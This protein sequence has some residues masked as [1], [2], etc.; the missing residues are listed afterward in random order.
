MKTKDYQG[1]FV[2]LCHRSGNGGRY[3][4]EIYLRGRFYSC[5]SNNSPAWDRV[6]CD[7]Y[8]PARAV[9]GGYT[10]KGAFRAL[11]NECKRKNAIYPYNIV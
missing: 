7:D 6:H 3:Y 2:K 10:L 4:V 11:Y 8:T 1:K 5:F 9:L